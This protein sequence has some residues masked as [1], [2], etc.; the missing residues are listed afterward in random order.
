MKRIFF[1]RPLVLFLIGAF[2]FFVAGVALGSGGGDEHGAKPKGW[3]A[4]DTYRV[5]N[6]AVLAIALF[7]VLRKP[8]SQSLDSRIK[9]IR[10]QLSELEAKK[11]VAEKELAEYNEKL[12]LLDQEAEK[13]VADYLKQGEEAKKRILAEAEAAA[14]KLEDQ[15]KR[16]IGQEFERAKSQLRE[17]IL[18]KALVKAEEIVRQRITD[19]DQDR[20]V[21]EYL[22]KVA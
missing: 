13:I 4:T 20:L 5:I 21:D 3:I 6:F 19:E 11:K 1:K 9:G 18:E 2:I 7:F 17:D 10:D 12:L 15:A 16:N 22:E 8:I 14:E